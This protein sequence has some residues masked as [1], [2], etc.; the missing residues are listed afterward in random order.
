[1]NKYYQKKARVREL[2][3]Y[4]QTLICSES[5]HSWDWCIKYQSMFE[6]LGKKYGLLRE[7]RENVII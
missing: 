5:S 6:R 1:M 3:I 2:A 4:W 7:F